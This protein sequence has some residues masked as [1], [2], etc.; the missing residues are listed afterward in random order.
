[1]TEPIDLRTIIL[2]PAPARD[3]VMDKIEAEQ[4]RFINLQFTDVMGIVKSVTIPTSVFEK[5]IDSGQWIDGSSI[6]GFTRIAE[7][8]MYLIPD[9]S[10]FVTIPWEVG[11][12]TT[13]RVICWV[14][15]PNGDPFPGDPR[16]VLYRQLERLARLGYRYKTGPELEFFLFSK[17]GDRISPLPHDR[18]GYFDYSTDV[19]STVRKD[20]VLALEQMGIEVEA[21]H[22]EVAIGQHEI[23]FEYGDALQTADRALTFKSVL[24]AVAQKHD[25]H[26]TFMPKPL[27][28]IA[29]SGMHVHQSFA[30]IETNENAFVDLEDPYGLSSLAKQL[31]AGQIRHARALCG[32]IAPLVNSYRRLVPG[33]EAPV[34]V[35]WA[36]TNRSAMLRV[37]AI[38]GGHTSATRV[39]LRCP[40]PSCNP[41]LAFTVMLAA[42][43]HGIEENLPLPEPVEENLYLFTDE[44]LDRRNIP[45]LP[46]SLGEAIQEM[47]KDE[48]IRD[49]LG[50]HVFERLLEAQRTDWTAFRRHVSQ[51]ERDRYLENY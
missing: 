46:A 17:D 19:A 16:W 21:S 45:T 27:E 11:D 33:F 18:A 40:D 49:A 23:D 22:H 6:A 25:L 10:T 32:V 26:A 39:E 34:Y 2:G 13:A 28:G 35:S 24:K 50:D 31:I 47:E 7:S 4:I 48:V 44:D 5:V 15:N 42:G 20:M 29:G 51:W 38:R 14:F 36:R 43:L 8:D 30:S 9:L 41:Y 1:M 37:P 3:V 12:Y